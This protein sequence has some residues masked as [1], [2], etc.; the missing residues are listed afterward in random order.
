MR[1]MDIDEK[2]RFRPMDFD[3]DRYIGMTVFNRKDTPPVVIMM[4]RKSDPPHYMVM[5]GMYKQLFYLRYADA[6]DYCKCMGYTQT[7]R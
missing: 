5:D 3:T 1:I 2:T 7:K 6:V 4:S